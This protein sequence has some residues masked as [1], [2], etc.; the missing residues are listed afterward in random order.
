MILNG[1][2]EDIFENAQILFTPG[3][4]RGIAGRYG[5]KTVSSLVVN[6]CEFQN[7]LLRHV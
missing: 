2:S 3:R 4:T 5:I 6:L 7:Q 1:K